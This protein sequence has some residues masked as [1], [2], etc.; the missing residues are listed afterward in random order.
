MGCSPSRRCDWGGSSVFL[1]SESQLLSDGAECRTQLAEPGSQIVQGICGSGLIDCLAL[2]LESG[3]LDELGRFE[4]G[5]KRFVLDAKHDV[6]LNERDIAELA[7]A[8]AAQAV[9]LVILASRLGIRIDDLERICIAG[10]FGRH[11]EP[12]AA[13]CIGLLPDVDPA[14]I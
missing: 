12:R 3:R 5:S 13:Q 8:K 7:Q 14:S 9:G 2:L 6:Y 1:N 4:T 10:A 11:L